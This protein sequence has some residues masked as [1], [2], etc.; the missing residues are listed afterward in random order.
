MK[1]SRYSNS[2]MIWRYQITKTLMNSCTLSSNNQ[3]SNYQYRDAL[4]TWANAYLWPPLKKI[5]GKEIF[6]GT[7]RI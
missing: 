5:I 2:I 3:F 6:F 1:P 7:A 4:P